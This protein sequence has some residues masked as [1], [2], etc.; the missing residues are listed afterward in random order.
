MNWIFV[1]LNEKMSLRINKI[2]Q[3]YILIDFG[4]FLLHK[5][6]LPSYLIENNYLHTKVFR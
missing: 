3:L 1:Y 4:Q 2:D 6:N 5:N